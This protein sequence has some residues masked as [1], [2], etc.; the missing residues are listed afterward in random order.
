MSDSAK[1]SYGWFS[2]TA[3]KYQNTIVTWKTLKGTNVNVSFVTDNPHDS[4]TK[5]KDIKYIGN[6]TSS[7]IPISI[8][9]AKRRG[10][11]KKK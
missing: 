5:F 1:K 8:A 3:Q 7:S 4:G 2:P 11:I 10:K 9:N 6:T